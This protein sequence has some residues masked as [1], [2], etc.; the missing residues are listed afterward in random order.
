V[1]EY[2]CLP[3]KISCHTALTLPHKYEIHPHNKGL[4]NRCATAVQALATSTAYIG[5]VAVRFCPLDAPYT[6]KSCTNAPK[7]RLSVSLVGS[8]PG[9]E[10]PCALAV[11]TLERSFSMVCRMISSSCVPIMGLRPRPDGY[12]DLRF[13]HPRSV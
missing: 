9:R 4:W 2:K 11:K 13:P 12:T 7:K 8:L 6:F 5:R 10:Y 1:T 3:W